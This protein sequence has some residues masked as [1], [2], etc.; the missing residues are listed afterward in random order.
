LPTMA[1]SSQVGPSYA[2]SRPI[3]TSDKTSSRGTDEGF[4]LVSDARRPASLHRRLQA[5]DAAATSPD[6]RY[7]V[8]SDRRALQIEPDALEIAFRRMGG[9]GHER[10]VRWQRSASPSRKPNQH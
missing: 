2:A 3:S 1:S 7:A 9:K 8:C 10:D 5:F 6:S 4:P